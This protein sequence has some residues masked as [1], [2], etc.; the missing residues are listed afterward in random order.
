MDVILQTH[1][2]HLLALREIERFSDR[3][4]FCCHLVVRA[5]GFR[6]QLRFCVE[7]EPFRAFVEAVERMD[8]SLTGSARLKPVFEDPFVEIT[9]LGGGKVKVRGDL[10]AHGELSQ[11]LTFEFLTDQTVLGPFARDLRACM[12]APAT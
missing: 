2:E 12:T 10:V 4:G 5:H 9:M 3:S 11:R 7:P 1:D 6:A 8:R